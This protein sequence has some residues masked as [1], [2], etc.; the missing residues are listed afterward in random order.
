MCWVLLVETVQILDLL[1]S[2]LQ[3]PECVLNG[4]ELLSSITKLFHANV[5]FSLSRIR[6]IVFPHCRSAD[7]SVQRA[8]LGC[9]GI[10]FSFVF[11]SL[12]IF[13]FSVQ[14]FETT[15]LKKPVNDLAEEELALLLGVIPQLIHPKMSWNLSVALQCLLSIIP[16]ATS[17]VS[18]I[19]RLYCRNSYNVE[20]GTSWS[21][22]CFADT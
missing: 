5:M 21:N 4:L 12:N 9:I 11:R 13:S 8:A 20:I 19:F 17:F 14:L 6:R 1:Q 16:F 18:C 7:Q 22:I 10:S 3:F 15:T 2:C